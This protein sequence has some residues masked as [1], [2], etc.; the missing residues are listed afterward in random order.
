MT[1]HTV[2]VELSKEIYERAEQVAQATQRPIE[3]VVVGWIH[4]PAK[5]NLTDVINALEDLPDEE[6]IKI[7]QSNISANHTDRLQELLS[8]QQQ[9]ELTGGEQREAAALVEQ[10]DFLTL[11]KARA[12]FLLKQRNALSDDLNMLLAQK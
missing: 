11:R 1:A 8:I 10:E 12:L 2:T 9:R 4:P 3:Q 7:A 6:L 5:K